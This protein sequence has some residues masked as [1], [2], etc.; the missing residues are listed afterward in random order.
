MV[1]NDVWMGKCNNKRIKMGYFK[2]PV[3]LYSSI[4]FWV[5]YLQGVGLI[6]E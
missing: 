2:A 5:A 4:C 6:I 3:L 1:L